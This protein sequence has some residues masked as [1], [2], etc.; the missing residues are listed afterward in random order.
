VNFDIEFQSLTLLT[1][2]NGVGKSTVFDVLRDISALVLD[3]AL[4][5]DVFSEKTLTRWQLRNRQIFEL[6]I[7]A[8]EGVYKY[9][10]I[11]AHDLSKHQCRVEEELLWFAGKLL[12]SFVE[13]QTQLFFDDGAP[14]PAFGMN[15]FRSGLSNITSGSYSDNRQYIVR[16]REYLA[17]MLVV[18][19][20]PHAIESWAKSPEE[21]PQNDLPNFVAWYRHLLDSEPNVV[22]SARGYLRDAIEGFDL[23]RLERSGDVYT[24]KVRVTDQIDSTSKK[25]IDYSW[26]E[27]SDG[28]KMLIMLY[29]LVEYIA[30]SPETILCLDE[31]DNFVSLQEIQPWINRLQ[32]VLQE[33]GVQ[34]I[35]TSHHP[36]YYDQFAGDC[37]VILSREQGGV[38]RNKPFQ[39]ESDNTYPISE[40]VQMGEI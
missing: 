33:Q 21:H 4:A 36:I 13:G 23:I 32:E 26:S 39:I 9:R 27:L 40:L 7:E 3:S 31:P 19:I 18:K 29:I 8:H 11:I 20:T 35:I 34:T 16:F 2:K 24:L 10:L 1:G 17:K 38:I 28:Q 25:P 15:F 6:E 12:F 14:L 5:K 30:A 22:E 37:G